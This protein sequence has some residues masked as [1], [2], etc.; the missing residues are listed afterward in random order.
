MKLYLSVG[1]L[2]WYNAAKN[3]ENLTILD[4]VRVENLGDCVLRHGGVRIIIRMV[5]SMRYNNVFEQMHILAQVKISSLSLKISTS[6][7]C[8]NMLSE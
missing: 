2:I 6:R 4:E 8:S 3:Y 7:F 1:N 5:V